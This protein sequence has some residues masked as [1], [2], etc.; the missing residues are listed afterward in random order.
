MPH[1]AASSMPALSVHTGAHL[2]Q[3]IRRQ[4]FELYDYGWK[5]L[6]RRHYGQ[7]VPP[8]VSDGYGTLADNNIR[9]HLVAGAYDGV[10]AKEDIKM[11]Y[12]CM[13][14]S[15]VDVTYTELDLGHLDVCFGG[16]EDVVRLV[17]AMLSSP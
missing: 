5:A 13:Q 3:L 9:V 10:I 8:D 11:H 7:D 15:G 2:I 14:R 4:K 6:N 12:T 16:H 17:D 1:Y